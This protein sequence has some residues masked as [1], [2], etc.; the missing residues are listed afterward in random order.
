MSIQREVNNM[1]Y[2]YVFVGNQVVYGRYFGNTVHPSE[3]VSTPLKRNASIEFDQHSS[4]KK[5]YRAVP[6]PTQ[7]ILNPIRTLPVPLS[8]AFTEMNHSGQLFIPIQNGRFVGI[9]LEPE[10]DAAVIQH[11]VLVPDLPQV[12]TTRFISRNNANAVVLI[13]KLIETED[14][15]I[16]FS[17]RKLKLMLNEIYEISISRRTVTQIRNELN[18]PDS[19][20]RRI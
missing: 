11:P 20:T 13:K 14:K 5:Q 9:E 2:G 3:V 19:L 12:E 16:P 8:H 7:H 6:L 1:S 18:F 4:P 10:N 15:S 17:D